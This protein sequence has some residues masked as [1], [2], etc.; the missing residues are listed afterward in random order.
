MWSYSVSLMLWSKAIPKVT[1]KPH[2]KSKHLCRR[3]MITARTKLNNSLVLLPTSKSQF[4]K[5]NSLR[6]LLRKS[7]TVGNASLLLF[8]PTIGS[9]GRKEPSLDV[10]SVLRISQPK[11]GIIMPMKKT[12]F[13]WWANGRKYQLKNWVKIFNND[14][15]LTSAV[16]DRLLHHAQTIPIEGKSYRMKDQIEEP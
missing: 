6:F 2:S 9:S 13:Y 14:A 10:E 12:Q 5:L 3:E 7:P 8:I 16:L 15:T 4:K 1:M 11:K